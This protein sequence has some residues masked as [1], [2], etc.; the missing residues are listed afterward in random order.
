MQQY[1]YITAL[2]LSIIG[3]ALIDR[4][5]G[6]SY[7]NNKQRTVL[8]IGVS[9]SVFI[10]WDLIGISLGIFFSGSSKYMM[11]YFIVDQ[12]PIEELFFLLLL[13][14][15]ALNIYQVGRRIWPRI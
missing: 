4:K 10:V 2:L 14:Y 12:F 11:P 3:I 15:T 13:N 6:L 8:T 5:H 1:Y 9:I 7:W